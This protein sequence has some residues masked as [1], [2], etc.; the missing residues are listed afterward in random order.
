MMNTQ[1][2]K[3][4]T[5]HPS[6]WVHGNAENARWIKTRMSPTKGEHQSM[7]DSVKEPRHDPRV[8]T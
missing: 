5:V 3:V 1:S 7:T 4:Y 6:A 2:N 8:A